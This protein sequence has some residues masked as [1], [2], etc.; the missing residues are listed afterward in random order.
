[1]EKI[2]QLYSALQQNLNVIV[3]GPA[4]SGKTVIYKTLC[5]ALNRIHARKNEARVSQLS[6]E[7]QPSKPLATFRQNLPKVRRVSLCIV[8]LGRLLWLTVLVQLLFSD[9]NI[10]LW[11]IWNFP[12]RM[13]AC[14]FTYRLTCNKIHIIVIWYQKIHHVLL[15]CVVSAKYVEMWLQALKSSK[16]KSRRRLESLYFGDVTTKFGHVVLSRMFSRELKGQ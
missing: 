14:R 6:E 16:T 13:A 2:L 11:N 10:E 7:I 1:M 9:W 3:C 8:S 4:G 12:Y 5:L 15:C